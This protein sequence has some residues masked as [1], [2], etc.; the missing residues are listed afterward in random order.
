MNIIPEKIVIKLQ[1]DFVLPNVLVKE[2]INPV[3][4]LTN[5]R[6]AYKNSS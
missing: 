2:E 5:S 3:L 1:A 6:H 4:I